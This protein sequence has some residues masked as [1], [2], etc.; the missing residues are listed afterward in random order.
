MEGKRDAVSMMHKIQCVFLQFINPSVL[1]IIQSSIF[2]SLKSFL[3]IEIFFFYYFFPDITFQF[4]RPCFHLVTF[5][6]FAYLWPVR[7]LVQSLS[8]P[9]IK[10]DW[11]IFS[12]GARSFSES[13]LV[14]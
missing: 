8:F 10:F 11:L 13:H 1:P 2:N 7:C 3:R 12:Q 6:A 9:R 14:Q 4:I 5:Y